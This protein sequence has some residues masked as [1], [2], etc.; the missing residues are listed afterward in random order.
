MCYPTVSAKDEMAGKAPD[1]L[2]AA[3]GE[4]GQKMKP[5]DRGRR[6]RSEE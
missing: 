1:V 3:D 2:A 5:P 4:P 6:D